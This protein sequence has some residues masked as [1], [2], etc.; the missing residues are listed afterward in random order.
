MCRPGPAAEIAA[1]RAQ[2]QGNAS[3]FQALMDLMDKY[4][5]VF[6]IIEPR[7]VPDG[8]LGVQLPRG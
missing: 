6:E 5:R 3:A 8:A 4:E 7:A 2:A 1:G